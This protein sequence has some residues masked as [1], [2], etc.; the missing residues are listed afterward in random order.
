MLASKFLTSKSKAFLNSQAITTHAHRL[1]PAFASNN[2]ATTSATTSAGIRPLSSSSTSSS[3][4]QESYPNI[5]VT[6]HDPPSP[7]QQGHLSVG[8]IEL[9]RP[10]ALNSLCD[11]LIEDLLH[12]TEALDRME[13]V[14]SIV[15]TGKGKAFAAGADI[16]E[17]SGR[18]F[19]HA[20]KTV[21]SL[22]YYYL[23]D[24]CVCVFVCDR[25][26]NSIIHDVII[27]YF[28]VI[29]CTVI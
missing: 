2:S 23:F 1:L 6:Q 16:E 19:A 11:G 24:L 12:A 27:L 17:M 20:Y 29:Y 26:Y 4:L 18:D 14:G 9:N 3:L 8:M 25:T 28:T 5:I 10:R 21:R 15:I 22:Y 7:I 13:G